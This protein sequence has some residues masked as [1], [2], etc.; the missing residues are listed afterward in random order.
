MTERADTEAIRQEVALR[1]FDFPDWEEADGDDHFGPGE[2]VAIGL[3][4]CV[5]LQQL[6]SSI[7]TAESLVDRALSLYRWIRPATKPVP[8]EKPAPLSTREKLFTALVDAHIRGGGAQMV[9]RLAAQFGLDGEDCAA[10]LAEL[11]A[12]GLA[13]KH[14]GGWMFR[15]N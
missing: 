7:D 4:F 1:I 8:D 6:N 5:G 13:R 10:A 11:D 3:A 12:L 2:I 9:D 15:R 14:D